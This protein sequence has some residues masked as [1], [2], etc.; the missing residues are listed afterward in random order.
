MKSFKTFVT[1][2]GE[3][4]IYLDMDG[5]LADFIEEELQELDEKLTVDHK[6]QP[7]GNVIG[8]GVPAAV[9]EAEADEA[10]AAQRDTENAE[11]LKKA[12]KAVKDLQEHVEKLSNTYKENKTK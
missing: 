8:H 6:P 11:E 2:E 3:G 1:E 4:R 12:Q 7:T 10:L 9:A 5:V